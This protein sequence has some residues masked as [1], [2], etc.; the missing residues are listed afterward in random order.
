M[1]MSLDALPL[2]LVLLAALMHAGWNMI[3]KLGDDRLVAMALIKAPNILLSCAVLAFVGLPSAE[4]WPYLLGSTV[5][6]CLY[7]YFLI[8]AYRAGDLSL[9]YPVARGTAPVLVLALAAVAVGELPTPAAFAGVTLIC[10]AILALGMQRHAP[11]KHEALLWAGGVGL[12]I[13][14]Y[15]VIDGIGGRLSGTPV[16]YV[17]V[18]N[19][20]TGVAICG[21]TACLRGRVFLQALR[22]NWMNGLLGGT[23]MLA[24][25][26][27]VVY[28]LTLAPMAQVAALRETSVIFAALLGALLLREPF[29]AKRIVASIG[30][31]A[32]IA[33]L[34]LGG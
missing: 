12:C 30:V 10:F 1:A 17:A 13:A 4:S 34:A 28:A 8:H 23:M 21:T 32:G 19:V 2:A 5:V 22:S 24:S 14:L 6:N 33:I 20:F 18:L 11:A 9:A 31:A 26:A 15:T 27:I 7:F 29:G 16:G 25:Y 3:A